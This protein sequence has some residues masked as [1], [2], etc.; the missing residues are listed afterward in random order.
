M[1]PLPEDLQIANKIFKVLAKDI[2]FRGILPTD[3]FAYH[4]VIRFNFTA[5]SIVLG[6]LL[7]QRL[8]EISSV[9]EL[10]VKHP[11]HEGRLSQ[12]FLEYRSGTHAKKYCLDN[13]LRLLLSELSTEHGAGTLPTVVILICCSIAAKM[14]DHSSQRI[15]ACIRR[16]FEF[17]YE[18]ELAKKLLEKGDDIEISIL[19][20]LHWVIIPLISEEDQ[21]TIDQI[22]MCFCICPFHH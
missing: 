3:Q 8:L 9:L 21:K 5:F 11:I 1:P 19:N 7:F 17:C 2:S 13:N 22:C 12:E 18:K 15:P 10:L 16:V 6:S 20:D 14:V 4:C